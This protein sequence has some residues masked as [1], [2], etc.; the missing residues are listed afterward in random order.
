MTGYSLEFPPRAYGFP[1]VSPEGK[2]IAV[3]TMDDNNI[4]IYDLSGATA[5]RKLTFG[6]MNRFPNLVS[7]W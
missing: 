1:R 4:W 5:T 6:G 3:Q 7:Q 2:R